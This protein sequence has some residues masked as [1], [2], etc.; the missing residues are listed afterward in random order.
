MANPEYVEIVKQGK[1][2]IDAWR[3]AHP[4]ER[5]D[6]GRADLSGANLSRAHLYLTEFQKGYCF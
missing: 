6:L 4:D 5:L 3:E 2:S 1:D